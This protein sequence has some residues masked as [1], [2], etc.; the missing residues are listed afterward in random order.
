M[1]NAKCI[2]KEALVG[3]SLLYTISRLTTIEFHA[4]TEF[5]IVLC[6]KKSLTIW[7]CRILNVILWH[8]VHFFIIYYHA[9][10]ILYC[11]AF[12]LRSCSAI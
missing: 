9:F 3:Q 1:F 5:Y 7:C 8:N 4:K 12:F 10:E 11:D 2:S 6:K